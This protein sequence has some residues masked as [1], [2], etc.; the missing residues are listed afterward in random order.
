MI[1]CKLPNQLAI[2]S[3][4]SIY[5]ILQYKY[6]SNNSCVTFKINER[7]IIIQSDVVLSFFDLAVLNAIHS[8]YLEFGNCKKFSLLNILK[9]LTGNSKAHF[10]NQSKKSNTLSKESLLCSLEKLSN[11][12]ILKVEDIKPKC[13]SLINLRFKNSYLTLLETPAI[14]KM[15]ED[16]LIKFKYLLI[17]SLAIG[18]NIKNKSY[19]HQT[20]NIIEFKFYILAEIAISKEVITL[21]NHKLKSLI[22]SKQQED[23]LDIK[24]KNGMLCYDYFQK[25]KNAINRKFKNTYLVGFLMNLK[26]FDAI[27]SFRIDSQQI[28]IYLK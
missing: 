26:K 14:F 6:S 11:F 9:I 27:K 3:S 23:E 2:I 8:I 15:Y 7:N 13:S 5:Q 22:G 19:I 28:I 21:D 12:K 1:K 18:F 4:K 20:I 24:F 16:G 25:R 17:D 10:S